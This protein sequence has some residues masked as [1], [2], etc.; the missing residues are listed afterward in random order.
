MD[1]V[2]AKKLKDAGF[3]QLPDHGDEMLC[4]ICDTC[5]C[6]CEDWKGH[7]DS[8]VTDP[9]LEQLIEACGDRFGYLKLLG[10]MRYRELGRWQVMSD[11]NHIPV[12]CFY[13]DE[14]IG[15]LAQLW[16]ALNTPQPSQDA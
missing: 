2:T 10:K 9:T 1:Y 15:A 16:L 4:P 11:G 7:E 12:L 5:A 6:E 14:A 8:Y 13:H 3:P